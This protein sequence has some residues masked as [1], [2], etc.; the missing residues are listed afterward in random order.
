MLVCKQTP[1]NNVQLVHRPSENATNYL[2]EFDLI[3][4]LTPRCIYVYISFYAFSLR[5][6]LFKQFLPLT[7]ERYFKKKYYRFKEYLKTQT[8]HGSLM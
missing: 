5:R 7:P 6:P 8:E 2:K 3:K 1:K 4:E